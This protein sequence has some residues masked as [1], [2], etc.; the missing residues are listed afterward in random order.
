MHN[1]W[2]PGHS[3]LEKEL[4][5]LAG[6]EL[7]GGF[8][9]EGAAESSPHFLPLKSMGIFLMR[10]WG[11]QVMLPT[12]GRYSQPE[13]GATHTD[14]LAC[15]CGWGGGCSQWATHTRLKDCLF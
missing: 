13:P 7:G 3:R 11:G 15:H 1:S 9:L 12:L 2:A 14:A 5:S 8:L 4:E 6:E 10:P